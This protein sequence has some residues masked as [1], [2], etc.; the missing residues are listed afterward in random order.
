MRQCVA[1][2]LLYL[3]GVGFLSRRGKVGLS[4]NTDRFQEQKIFIMLKF[5]T[6]SKF[7]IHFET[8]KPGTR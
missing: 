4:L 1:G 3:A 8:M 2:V 5:L 7:S 6:R